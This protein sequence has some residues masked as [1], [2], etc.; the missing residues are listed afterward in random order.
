MK[1]LKVTLN[2]NIFTYWES[3]D[4]FPSSNKQFERHV[5]CPLLLHSQ[6]WVS[7]D[8]L[9]ISPDDRDEDFPNNG[10]AIHE[11]CHDLA[12]EPA[13][14]QKKICKVIKV[15]LKAKRYEQG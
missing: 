10:G 7:L 2:S 1:I 12:T 14:A 11:Y 3:L 9:L 5:R 13:E 8:S 4:L 6:A 15:Y